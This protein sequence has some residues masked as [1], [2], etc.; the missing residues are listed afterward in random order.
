MIRSLESRRGRNCV[1]L[2]DSVALERSASTRESPVGS[3]PRGNRCRNWRSEIAVA[4]ERASPSAAGRAGNGS[5][6]ARV[7]K[8][9]PR[10]SAYDLLRAVRAEPTT[11]P[12]ASADTACRPVLRESIGTLRSWRRTS[13]QSCRCQ[14]RGSIHCHEFSPHSRREPETGSLPV[15]DPRDNNRDSIS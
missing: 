14:S 3:S 7:L 4:R 6:A 1:H 12:R 2:A 5:L 8:V 13:A 15:E 11:P 9:V 10:S